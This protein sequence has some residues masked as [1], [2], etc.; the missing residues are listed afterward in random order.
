MCVCV[1]MRFPEALI[2]SS[3]FVFVTP[4]FLIP[5]RARSDHFDGGTGDGRLFLLLRYRGTSYRDIFFFLPQLPW[6][7]CGFGC[8]LPITCGGSLC[9][10]LTTPFASVPLLV[11]ATRQPGV[12]VEQ[13]GFNVTVFAAS[14]ST[15][16]ELQPA[17]AGE[18]VAQVPL[19]FA[20]LMWGG[21]WAVTVV[22]A[23]TMPGFKITSLFESKLRWSTLLGSRRHHGPLL[24]WPSLVVAP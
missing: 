2:L 13:T 3:T 22:G 18:A 8:V 14:A 5:H 1:R 16:T 21:I 19:R 20:L 7:G 23:G 10:A 4:F 11:G 24:V 15:I 9:L 17:V 6:L 12:L